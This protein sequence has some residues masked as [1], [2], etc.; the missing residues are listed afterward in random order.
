MPTQIGELVV[1]IGSEDKKLKKGL[2]EAGEALTKFEGEAKKLGAALTKL[3]TVP[4]VGIATAAFTS[5]SRTQRI[6]QDFAAETKSIFAELGEEIAEAIDLEG[7]LKDT[8]EALRNAVNWFREFSVSQ[9]ETIIEI[10]ALAAILGPAILLVGE[11]AAFLSV[12][13]KALGLLK[14]GILAVS[15]LM[16]SLVGVLA[17][18]GVAIGT[19]AI[20]LRKGREEIAK[21]AKQSHEAALKTGGL[22]ELHKKMS[23]QVQS[24]A[25][26]FRILTEEEAK[27]YPVILQL[28]EGLEGLTDAQ[29]AA[30]QQH[31]EMQQRARFVEIFGPAWESVK[32]FVSGL[33][34]LRARLV[35]VHDAVEQYRLGMESVANQTEVLGEL[36]T[37]HEAELGMLL[38]LYDQLR[39]QGLEPTAE[40]MVQIK[41]RIMELQSPLNEFARNLERNMMTTGQFIYQT[42]DAAATGI[43]QAVAQSIVYGAKLSEAMMKAMK[44]VAAQVIASLVKIAIQWVV[45]RVLAPLVAT[46]V[47]A[48][49]IAA[50]FART[51]AAATAAAFEAGGPLGFVLAPGFVAGALGLAEAGVASGILAGKAASLQ[52]LGAGGAAHGG[53]FTQPATTRIAELG[54]PEMV[55]N[56]QNI[57]RF[58]PELMGRGRQVLH[59]HL[60]LDG[61]EVA[62]DLIPWIPGELRHAGAT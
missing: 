34:E 27:N 39:T 50:S 22:G 37:G 52:I 12:A 41:D 58:F 1:K 26:S 31:M 48:P 62:A 21:L 11:F 40:A 32:K 8:V 46:S 29:K 6:F 15:A 43:G 47:A 9:R 19:Y 60:Y 7:I 17:V 25:E 10:A 53:I 51:A 28:T 2:K 16:W 30:L 20:H 42:F 35:A 18:A 14:T 38:Q 61:R 4:I 55:L 23:E 24:E 57:R 45:M 5:S 33:V 3:V 59:A 54:K 44:A 56:E 36:T 49:H 13:V